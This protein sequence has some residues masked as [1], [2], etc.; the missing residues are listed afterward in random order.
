[1]Y[2]FNHKRLEQTLE[3]WVV[4]GAKCKF[5]NDA[6]ELP[7]TNTKVMPSDVEVSDINIKCT[8]KKSVL[9]VSPLSTVFVQLV[10]DSSNLRGQIP[11]QALINPHTN[12]NCHLHLGKSFLSILTDLE[13][14]A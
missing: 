6:A 11:T 8:V 12:G 5:I 3:K 2:K 1:M 4:A 10:M 13:Q 9:C 14:K 7:K